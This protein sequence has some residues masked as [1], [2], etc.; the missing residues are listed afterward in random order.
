M[1]YVGVS[2]SYTAQLRRVQNAAARLLSGTRKYEHNPPILASL[3]WLPIHFTIC[4]KLLL[5]VFK[6][7]YL[8][9]LLHPPA[10]S[11]QLISRSS[12]GL[13]HNVSLGGTARYFGF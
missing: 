5:F 4:F 10:H 8:C 2:G 12:M 7:S 11:G 1:H 3:Q 6:T 9:E 13:K